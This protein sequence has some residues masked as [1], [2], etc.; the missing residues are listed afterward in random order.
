MLTTWL[1]DDVLD[2][3][4]LCLMQPVGNADCFRLRST[5]VSWRPRTTLLLLLFCF[6]GDVENSWTSLSSLLSPSAARWH[7]LTLSWSIFSFCVII[8]FWKENNAIHCTKAR[9]CKNNFKLWI[10][11]RKEWTETVVVTLVIFEKSELSVPW[12]ASTWLQQRNT[13][14]S[15]FRSSPVFSKEKKKKID[16]LF[17]SLGWLWTSFEQNVS[18]AVP[19]NRCP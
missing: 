18:V 15:S 8:R 3:F 13:L 14:L 17:S 12:C 2:R 11:R 6:W 16:I 9:A 10:R 5:Y 7:S 1:Y 4:R 19:F